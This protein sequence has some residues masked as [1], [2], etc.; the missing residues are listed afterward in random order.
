MNTLR[1]VGDLFAP[2]APESRL[3]ERFKLVADDPR[4]APAWATMRATFAKMGERDPSFIRQFQTDGFDARCSELY[5]YAALDAA[6]FDVSMIGDA[7][8]FIVSG[9]G[10]DWAI[11]ATTANPSGGGPPPPVPDDRAELQR[12]VGGEL[13][14]RLG[15]ALYSKLTHRPPYWELPHVAGKPFVVA[16]QNFASDDSLHFA[17]TALVHYLYGFE[18]H[19]ERAPDGRLITYT[20][21]VEMISGEKKEIPSGFFATDGAEHISAVL[22]TNSGTIMKF[23]R[24]GFQRGLDSGGIRRMTRSGLRFVPGGEADLPAPFAYDVGSRWESWEEG[25]VMAH[26]PNALLP[27][28]DDCFPGIVHHSIG[29]DGEY[30]G[31]DPSFVA[32][33]SK[34]AIEV[35][36]TD[37]DLAT[38][39]A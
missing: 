17:D 38:L 36:T 10:H 29:P 2:A 19:A 39:R 9:H 20:V 22:W 30:R 18:S 1:A 6:G 7:P 12:Y 3:D 24:M 37:T 32:F 23:A 5:L 4:Y 33:N 11:E 27:L 15:S 26:N 13:I 28:S 14:V 31:L 8:D 25:L 21:D 16:I 34:T 35:R